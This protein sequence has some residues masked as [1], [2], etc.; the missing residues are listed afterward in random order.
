[1]DEPG[2]SDETE[3]EFL[4]LVITY[5]LFRYQ[6]FLL[7]ISE[8]TAQRGRIKHGELIN[9]GRELRPRTSGRSLSS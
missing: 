1:M 6:K 8:N 4:I 3:L 9:E 5:S 2:I 7:T